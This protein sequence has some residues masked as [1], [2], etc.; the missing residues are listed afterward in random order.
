MWLMVALM[1]LMAG[2]AFA[3]WPRPVTT[4]GTVTTNDVVVF[5]DATGKYIKSGGAGGTNGF[6]LLTD[7][8]YLKALTNALAGAGISVSITGHVVTISVN[9]SV[10]TNA[11]KDGTNGCLRWMS[12]ATNENW[13]IP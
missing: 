4:Q 7:A 11:V 12:S 3:Q 5:A 2:C 10:P 6:V 13:I 1:L 8:V 9:T